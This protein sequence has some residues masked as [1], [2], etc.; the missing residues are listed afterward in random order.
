MM[1]RFLFVAADH[2]GDTH[3]EHRDYDDDSS[4][5]T[6]AA[7]RLRSRSHASMVHVYRLQGRDTCGLMSFVKTLQR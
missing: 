3:C 5:L 1:Y 6:A 4:A 7:H 2:S